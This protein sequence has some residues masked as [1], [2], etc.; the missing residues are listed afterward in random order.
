MLAILLR[1]S[2]ENILRIHPK[3]GIDGHRSFSSV[4]AHA[5]DWNGSFSARIGATVETMEKANFNLKF[6]ALSAY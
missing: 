2:N 3:N 4:Y 5:E 1:N 6:A